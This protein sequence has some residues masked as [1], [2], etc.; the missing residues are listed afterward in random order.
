MG[1]LISPK[2][3]GDPWPK[4]KFKLS[5]RFKIS[6]QLFKAFIHD[7][8]QIEIELEDSKNEEE[9]GIVRQDIIGISNGRERNIGDYANFDPNSMN[10]SII[11][12]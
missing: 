1:K 5:R 10:T 9:Y 7:P 3:K 12:T 8:S 2:Y 6:H 4:I 11:R